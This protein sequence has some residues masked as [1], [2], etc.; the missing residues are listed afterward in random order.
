M[1]LCRITVLKLRLLTPC[2]SNDDC[3]MSAPL[4]FALAILG[5]SAC[6]PFNLLQWRGSSTMQSNNGRVPS[7]SIIFRRQLHKVTGRNLVFFGLEWQANLELKKAIITT[8]GRS[9]W[10]HHM[11]CYCCYRFGIKCFLCVES[12]TDVVAIFRFFRYEVLTQKITYFSRRE[13]EL[14]VYL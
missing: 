14:E 8:I 7:S 3:T 10:T 4:P 2:R 5:C 6:P 9:S 11:C 13:R 12:L 1:F